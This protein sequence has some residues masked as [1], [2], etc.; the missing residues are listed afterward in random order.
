MKKIFKGLR[1]GDPPVPFHLKNV[2]PELAAIS[3]I[4]I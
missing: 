1:P 2:F 4:F 3:E